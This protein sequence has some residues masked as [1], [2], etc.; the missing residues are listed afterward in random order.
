MT[1]WPRYMEGSR[2]SWRM[3]QAR[4]NK[5][6]DDGGRGC[7]K[8]S[9]IASFMDDPL[10]TTWSQCP[11]SQGSRLHLKRVVECL[12]CFNPIILIS[13]SLRLVFS[14]RLFTT[15]IV[16]PDFCAFK[17]QILLWQ[18]A[19]GNYCSQ[20]GWISDLKFGI[21]M[22]MKLNAVYFIAQRQIFALHTKFGEIDPLF[23]FAI[24]LQIL[25]RNNIFEI[26]FNEW[27]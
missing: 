24:R 20:I 3:H 15:P 9:K 11:H 4:C 19:F 10:I 17:I 2:I 13:L 8:L 23:F 7:Q 6:R 12:R 16:L 14:A 1:S 22:L 18:I 27:T 26:C 21:L 5:K 25:L